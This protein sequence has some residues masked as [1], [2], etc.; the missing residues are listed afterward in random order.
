MNGEVKPAPKA[1]AAKDKG[2]E[3]PKGKAKGRR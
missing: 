2:T 1:I 3:K